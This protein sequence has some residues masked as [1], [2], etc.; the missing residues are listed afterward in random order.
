MFSFTKIGFFTKEI[1]FQENVK[2]MLL[3]YSRKLVAVLFLYTDISGI[4]LALSHIKVHFAVGLL[5][6]TYALP[7]PEYQMIF[8]M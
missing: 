4:I 5:P 8:L 1:S 3:L 2:E 7:F 6:S